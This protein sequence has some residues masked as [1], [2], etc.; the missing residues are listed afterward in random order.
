ML[1]LTPFIV[2][3]WLTCLLFT[4]HHLVERVLPQQKVECQAAEKA[5]RVKAGRERAEKVEREETEKV[6]DETS[7]SFSLNLP[8]M[9]LHVHR[10]R[11]R[12]HRGISCYPQPVQ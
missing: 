2:V 11:F 6:R 3:I 1:L 10:R 12:S 5:E 7:V 9:T 4:N 8:E